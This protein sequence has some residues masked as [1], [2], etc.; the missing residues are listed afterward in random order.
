VRIALDDDGDGIPNTRDNAPL[1]YNPDQL[2]RDQDGVG[3]MA[4][5]CPERYNPSQA[6][7]DGDG[8]GDACVNPAT[9]QK[10]YREALIVPEETKRPG[11]PIW[12]KAS[13]VNTSGRELLTFKPDCIN[14]VF[15]IKDS[16]GLQLHPIIKEKIYAIPRDL[17][18]IPDGGEFSVTCDLSEM[19]HPSQ[20][21]A[22]EDQY[23][24]QASYGNHARDPD[25]DPVTGVCKETPCLDL[26]IGA[27]TSPKQHI[28]IQGEA[29]DKK[30][31][32]SAFDPTTWLVQ[33]ASM[34]GPPIAARM[35]FTGSGLTAGAIDPAS[36]R[37]NGRVPIQGSA[38]VSGNA[39]TV[40]FNR[41]QA[42]QSFGSVVP[43]SRV[44][45]AVQGRTL[46]KAFSFTTGQTI[47]L[48]AAIPVGVD[49][50]PGSHPNAVN[51]GSSGVLPVAILSTAGFDA[52]TV[53]PATVTLAGSHV[54]LKGKGTPVTSVYDVNGDGRLDL[55]VHVSTEALQLSDTDSV[56]VLEGYTMQGEPII[57]SDSV[58]VVP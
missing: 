21:R 10:D 6:D 32:K 5:N 46:D 58:R 50:K 39:L 19:F 14:T 12:V 38:T 22:Q 34:D 31:A 57:G 41:S 54:Q 45:A 33:W 27:V 11:E 15:T 13:F 30:N 56:A 3:D 36:I 17:I 7:E 23:E 20:L 24:V 1:I 51:L 49:I 4:D 2:D 9:G 44:F 47:T 26:W 28:S 55:V 18:A 29:L 48:A 37:L 8:V 25:I 40:H 52:R 16:L 35:D 42:V 53:N 43:G